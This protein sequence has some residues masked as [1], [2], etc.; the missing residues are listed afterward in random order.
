MLRRSLRNRGI[1]TN[2][3]NIWRI[4]DEYGEI[5]P[6]PFELSVS[7][8]DSATLAEDFPKGITRPKV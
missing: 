8:D 4:R 7:Y 1:R 2:T 3:W 5:V 6:A